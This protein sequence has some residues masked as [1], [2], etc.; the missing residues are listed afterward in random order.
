[1][2]YPRLLVLALGSLFFVMTACSNDGG[3]GGTPSDLLALACEDALDSVYEGQTPPSDWSPQMRGD[4]TRCAFERI[5]SIEEMA[6]AFTVQDTFI[7]PGLSTP[8]Y[9]YRIQYWMER[10]AGEPLL[11][12]AV[13]YIPETRRADPSPVVVLGHGSV[14]IADECAPSLENPDGFNKDWRVLAYSYAADG[15]ISIMPDNPGL[16]T[17]GTTAWL[18]SVDEGHAIL[19]ATRA[20]RKL[21]N[22]DALTD[23]NALIGLSAGA[24]AVLSA[25]AF[26]ADYGS[27]GTIET[28][29]AQSPIWLTAGIWGALVS[30]GG[31][32]FIDSTLMSVTMQY[33]VGHLAVYE[34]EDAVADA[35]L[36][37][38]REPA[39]DMLNAG[40]WSQVTSD[41]QGPP[42]IG[43]DIGPDLF[44][45]DYVAEVGACGLNGVCEGDLALTWR[46]RWVVDRPPP[47][48][49]IPI[50]HWTGG[51]DDFIPPGFQ[52]CGLDRLEA[53]GADLIA[54]VEPGSDHSGVVPRTAAW[55]RQHLDEVLLGGDPP[56]PCEL[57]STFDPG[58]TCSIPL[59][60]NSLDP[61]DP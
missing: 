50:V 33:F 53:Q 11:T 57:L 20:A 1:M 43:V 23:K 17:P 26:A 54:S 40:C 36:S 5:V 46:E 34:G 6:E 44:L 48:T 47:N 51:I 49:T 25:Q 19:D 39:I 52:Q 16:G 35:F 28:V 9:K 60:P 41:D 14:G 32:L 8:V 61:S 27:D 55:V 18:Y 2:P 59:I 37:E 42:S 3:G 30:E 15:W 29:V 13:L 4:I 45:P 24:H 56:E 21:F 12:S 58:L 7:D 38:L 10:N 22:D 31:S